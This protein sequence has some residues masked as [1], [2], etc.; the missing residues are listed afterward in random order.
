MFTHPNTSS[1]WHFLLP[2]IAPPRTFAAILGLRR[3]PPTQPLSRDPV[4]LEHRC[5]SLQLIDQSNFIFPHPSIIPR[6]TGEL[7]FRRRSASP[8][9]RRYR[10]P[11]PQSRAPAALHQSPEA[12]QLL[13]H[14]LP[15]PQPA[16]RHAAITAGENPSR[17]TVDNPLPPHLRPNWVLQSNPHT[18]MML[19][20]TLPILVR[21]PLAGNTSTPSRPPPI[22]TAG[23]APPLFLEHITHQQAPLVP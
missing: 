7:K 9:T 1:P 20:C 19:M 21:R 4:L 22:L 17:H 13:L 6:S 10:A 5:D 2:S 23:R 18:S 14:R 11:Q 8:S 16:G 3:Q 12:I 15:T